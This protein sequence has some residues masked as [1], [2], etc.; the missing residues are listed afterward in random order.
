ME[1]ANS[2]KN[3][4]KRGKG[5]II[6]KINELNHADEFKPDWKLL[7]AMRWNHTRFSQWNFIFSSGYSRPFSMTGSPFNTSPMTPAN[8]VDTISK[9]EKTCTSASGSSSKRKR[10]NSTFNKNCTTI[11]S[12]WRSVY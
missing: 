8:E 11:K 6:V 2:K 10:C 1:S 3:W 9:T 12:N 5:N 4:D 7:Q